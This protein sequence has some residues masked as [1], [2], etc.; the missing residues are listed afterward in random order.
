MLLKYIFK[1]EIYKYLLHILFHILF[2]NFKN[3]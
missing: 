3:S 2:F 1:L